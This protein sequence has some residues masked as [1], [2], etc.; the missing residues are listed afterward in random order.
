MSGKVQSAYRLDHLTE[1]ALLKVK[2]DILTSLDQGNIMDLLLIDMS[3]AFDIIDH[4]VL[5]NRLEF[6][7]VIT[8]QGVYM[9]KSRIDLNRANRLFGESIL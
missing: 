4:K 5:L 9:G 6:T 7:Y 1:T 2:S 3:A 8:G